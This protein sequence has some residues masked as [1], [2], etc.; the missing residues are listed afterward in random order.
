MKPSTL[1]GCFIALCAAILII[2][3]DI[4]AVTLWIPTA[5]HH[6]HAPTVLGYIALYVVF[7][8]GNVLCWTATVAGPLLGGADDY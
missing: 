7:A 3:G 1:F 8:V 5:G 2:V 6:G 4:A